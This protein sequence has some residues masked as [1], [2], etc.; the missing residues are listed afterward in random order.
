MYRNVYCVCLYCIYIYIY[1][2]VVTYYADTLMWQ[3]ISI[4]TNTNNTNIN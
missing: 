2:T 1:T 4:A 3:F